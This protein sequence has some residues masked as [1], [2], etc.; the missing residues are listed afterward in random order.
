MKEFELRDIILTSDKVGSNSKIIM[1]TILRKVSWDTWRAVITQQYL[2]DQIKTISISTIKRSLCELE[3]INWIQRETIRKAAKNTPTTITVNIDEF[4][5]SLAQNE[6]KL[7]MSLAQNEPKVKFKM[8]S[9]TVQNEP[10]D[11]FKMSYNTIYNNNINNI[12]NINNNQNLDQQANSYDEYRELYLQLYNVDIDHARS[13][14]KEEKWSFLER[15]KAFPR[16]VHLSSLGAEEK[17]REILARFN[18]V[19]L[20]ITKA[21]LFKDTEWRRECR[22]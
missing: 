5:M 14:I 1:L 18:Y 4:K 10:K 3:E 17:E 21:N 22:K 7:K 2:K 6:P 19:G 9:S 20:P 12:N 13:Y 8:N 15:N 16:W 11:R